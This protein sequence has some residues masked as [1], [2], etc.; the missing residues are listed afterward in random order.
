MY[1]TDQFV[2]HGVSSQQLSYYFEMDNFGEKKAL[3]L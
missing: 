3:L 1:L 2:E